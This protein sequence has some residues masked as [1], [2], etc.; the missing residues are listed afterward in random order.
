MVKGAWWHSAHFLFSFQARLSF[1]R[2]ARPRSIV[3]L[4]FGAG[5]AAR[6]PIG[7]ITRVTMAE[8]RR[9]ADLLVG[10]A[11][12]EKEK[13]GRVGGRQWDYSTRPEGGIPEPSPCLI[14]RCRCS[15]RWT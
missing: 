9:M 12:L 8:R 4:T 1:A 10:V 2:K 14:G 13:E 3:P 7:R 6:A 5:S 11:R 15:P